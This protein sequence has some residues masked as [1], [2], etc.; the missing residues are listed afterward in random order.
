MAAQLL[1]ALSSA[2]VL[3][4]IELR[5]GQIHKF[6]LMKANLEI[7][8]HTANMEKITGKLCDRLDMLSN[9]LRLEYDSYEAH[10]TPLPAEAFQRFIYQA[11][12][13]L[14]KKTNQVVESYLG[15]PF[16]HADY[17]VLSIVA[18]LMSTVFLHREVREKGGAYGT[19]VITDPHKGTISVYSQNDPRHLQTF[20]AFEK[21]ITKCAQ[22]EFE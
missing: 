17:A 15:V 4:D 10:P 6:V 19:G 13:T 12:F 21:A 18:E 16:A 5:L 2:P 1:Q 20:V 9:A 3:K 11:Y 8:V 7:C 22:G 14:P